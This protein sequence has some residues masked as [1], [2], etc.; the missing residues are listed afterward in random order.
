MSKSRKLTVRAFD[1]L[2]EAEKQRIV[3]EIEQA[4]PG[5][6]WRKSRPM[7]DADRRRFAPIRARMGR[8]KIG[9]GVKIVSVSV[10]REL[11]DRA[12]A[13][14]KKQGLKRAEFF[15]AALR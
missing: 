8:P 2:G 15:T 9:K 14:A 11:L 10:E 7:T 5:E 6:I 3:K 12:D 13:Y 1:A 4:P